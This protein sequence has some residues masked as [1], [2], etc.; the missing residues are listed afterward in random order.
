MIDFIGR[1]EEYSQ[2]QQLLKKKTAS[3]VVVYGRRRVGKSRLIEVFGEKLHTL[4]F[5][6]LAPREGITKQSQLDEFSRQL[7]RQLNIPFKRYL[8]WSNAFYDLAMHTK[9]EHTLILLDEITWMA[10][11]DPDFLGQLKNIWDLH[12]KKNPKLILT[13]CG[14]VSAWIQK[15]IIMSTG[16]HGRISLKLHLKEM[17]IEDC[18][19]FWGKYQN[20]VS[21]HEKLKM[22]AVMG[23]IPKYLEEIDPTMPAEENIRRLAFSESGILF[24]DYTQIF[25]DTLQKKSN[26][27]EKIIRLLKDGVLEAVKIN[28]LLNIES[29]GFLS[30]YLEEL[31]LSGFISRT[32]TWNLKNGKI[33]KLSTYRLSD[34]Y[35]RFYLNY[36][37]PNT[38]QIM[39]G[40]FINRSMTS[41]PAWSTIMSL[42]IENLVLA[43]R[44]KIKEL[45]R[46]LP[47][48]VICDN[49]FF[50][51]KTSKQ[52]GCQI[53][54]LIQTKYDSL[55]VCEIKYTRN[56][57]YKDVIEEV[58]EKIRRMTIPKH[59]SIR[60]V[61]IYA[62]ALHD[63][64][65]DA[66]YFSATIN[67]ECLFE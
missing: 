16:F 3:L 20:S 61:L 56:I 39:A 45:L 51:R 22:L 30:D 35:L 49:P 36:I 1:K 42:Q 6:G 19:Y 66:D 50:Q 57:I 7:A 21:N 40:N 65:I 11:E 58:K 24:N 55:Y 59:F 27:Y 15:N 2:L 32:S 29:G 18:K 13:L 67:L 37:E 53:D 41:L 5:S 38:E 47:E 4:M 10:I 60:T 52:K 23:G 63:E 64:V 8:D 17:K 31:T 48:D 43:N 62:G 14:S 54:Y 12:F 25:T 46:I 34:N 26:Y 9:K 44:G 33:S 28:K